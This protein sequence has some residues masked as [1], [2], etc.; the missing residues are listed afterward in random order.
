MH[1]VKYLVSACLCGIGSRFDGKYA[2]D[3]QIA[4]LVKKGRAI[5][6]C[7][8]ELGGLPV[9]RP[10]ADI[11]KGDGQNILSQQS[12]VIS[13]NEEDLTP[14]FLR[15]AFASV[16]IAKRFKIKKAILK[17]K[18][19]SCGCGWIKRKGKL[20]KGDGVTVALL[21]EEGIQVIPR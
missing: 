7:P 18:S 19:P 21:K 4:E 2:R 11:E 5:P 12:R 15:G 13:Q 1:K 10:P 9:P 3:D 14:F 16:R 17:R 6:V 20:V 8:E